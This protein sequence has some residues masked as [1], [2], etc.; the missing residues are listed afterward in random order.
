MGERVR[1]GTA[2]SAPSSS[3]LGA[4]SGHAKDVLPTCE[5]CESPRHAGGPHRVILV[6]VYFSELRREQH[7][8]SADN[9][10]SDVS[11]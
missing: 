8:I 1:L 6:E 7:G 3:T 5:A 10:V 11:H 9:R 2:L 4:R